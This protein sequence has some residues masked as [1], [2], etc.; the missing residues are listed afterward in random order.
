MSTLFHR[1][2]E[3]RETAAK[4]GRKSWGERRAEGSVRKTRKMGRAENRQMRGLSYTSLTALY[5][6]NILLAKRLPHT[7]HL[8]PPPSPTLPGLARVGV[9]AP[10]A[11]VR[12][13]SKARETIFSASTWGHTAGHKCHGQLMHTAKHSGGRPSKAKASRKA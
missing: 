1:P 3:G 4:M 12:R 9:L 2:S 13:L 11:A 7:Y 6:F 8:Q 10:F 5:I